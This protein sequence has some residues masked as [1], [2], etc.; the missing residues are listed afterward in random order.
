MTR[1]TKRLLT[2]ILVVLTVAI[3]ACSQAPDTGTGPTAARWDEAV[4][5]QDRW[6]E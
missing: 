3:S 1:S 2:R 5:D 6:A 4:W